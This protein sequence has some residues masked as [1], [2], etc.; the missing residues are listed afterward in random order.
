MKKNMC[1][2]AVVLFLFSSTMVYAYPSL[3][4]GPIYVKF[5]GQ[6]QI[7]P[8]NSI[9]MYG[10]ESSWGVFRVSS[11]AT[12]NVNTDPQD[13]GP[14]DIFWVDKLT[15]GGIITGIFFGTQLSDPQPENGLLSTGGEIHFYYQDDPSKFV[16]ID[17]AQVSDRTAQD[18]FTNF[19]DGLLLAK[20]AFVEDAH[21]AGGS[22]FGSQAV[23]DFGFSGSAFSFGDIIDADGDGDI[24]FDDGAW[25]ASLDSEYFNTLLGA[26]TADIRFENRY[27]R[28]ATG[29]TWD[30]LENGIF[31]AKFSDPGKANVVPEPS[32]LLLLGVGFLGL[33]A[34]G[35]RRMS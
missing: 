20:I 16:S 22:V 31:G 15:D 17:D 1:F 12:G 33:G 14:E 23:G 29:H 4:T 6:E 5:D 21:T 19:T 13:F 7:S 3:P 27:N 18:Q 35:R 25:A 32:T 11:I 10:P 9:N 30:D 28:D 24:D 34:F 8:T 26:N 2:F